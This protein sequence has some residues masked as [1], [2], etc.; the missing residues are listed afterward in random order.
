MD[1]KNGGKRRK[2][3]EEKHEL[4]EELQALKRRLKYPL[5]LA[6][7]ISTAMELKQNIVFRKG[8]TDS[9]IENYMLMTSKH[10]H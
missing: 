4:E 5:L 6:F 10:L 9:D 3:K 1:R 7:N 8:Q 2:K